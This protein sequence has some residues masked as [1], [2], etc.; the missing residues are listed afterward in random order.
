MGENVI[1]PSSSFRSIRFSGPRRP[2]LQSH[3]DEL[4]H[5]IAQKL[6]DQSK[7][8]VVSPPPS[9]GGSPTM[10]TERKEEIDQKK[11]SREEGLFHL[12]SSPS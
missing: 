11:K 3:G 2:P 9:Y 1:F 4:L 12:L 8:A 6:W 10:P 7:A 5:F